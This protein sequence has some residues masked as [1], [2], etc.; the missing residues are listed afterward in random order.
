VLEAS[1]EVTEV[2][3]GNADDTAEEVLNPWTALLVTLVDVAGV[4]TGD[5]ENAFEEVLVTSVALLDMSV[6]VAGMDMAE[7]D[8]T[9]LEVLEMVISLELLG[10]IAGVD[11]VIDMLLLMMPIPVEDDREVL[12][13]ASRVL[14]DLSEELFAVAELVVVL[15]MFDGIELSEVVE[16]V[17]VAEA[18]PVV[19]P[20]EL[21][22]RIAPQ[23][24]LSLIPRFRYLC[25]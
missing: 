6:D 9:A 12:E 13:V 2:D 4:D 20:V 1:A 11:E 21:K 8:C 19:V 14:E 25:K 3:E 23:T 24:E 17:E 7:P 15:I 22:T 18:P 10:T 16:A 5:A